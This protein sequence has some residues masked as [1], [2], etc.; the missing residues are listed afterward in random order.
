[1]SKVV[2]AINVMISNPDKITKA[3]KAENGTEIFFLYDGKH[4]WSIIERDGSDYYIHYYPGNPD[5]VR[6][7]SIPDQYWEEENIQSVMY[8]SKEL[9][10]KEAK[11]SMA[12]LYSV[13]SEKVYGMDDILEDIIQ[14]DSPF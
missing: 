12:E 10:T 9:G 1:M 7:A 5:I 11:E 14:S 2:K 6:L 13:V 4:P 3:I 8:S